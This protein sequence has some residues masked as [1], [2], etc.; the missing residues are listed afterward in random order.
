MKILEQH[1]TGTCTKTLKIEVP[2]DAV[3]TELDNVYKEF[4]ANAAVPGFRKGKAP[5]KIVQMRYGKHLNDE[6]INKAVEN[7]F[8]EA[9]EEIKVKPVTRA[10]IKKIEKDNEDQPVVVEF[11]FEHKPMFEL[12]DISSLQIEQPSTE[13]SETDIDQ[14]LNQM[15]E[16]NAVFTSI[17]DRPVMEND[18]VVIQ[19]KATF[20]DEP[21]PEGTNDEIQ[22]AVGSKRYIQGLEDALIGM[23][24]G[25]SKTVAL[26]LPDDFPDEEKRGKEVQFEILVK[27]IT[28]KTL[29]ELDDEFAKDI[30]PFESLEQL[31]ESLR[32]RYA[33]SAEQ[34]RH[35]KL[36][37]SIRQELLRLNQFDVP[38]SQVKAQYEYINTYQDS[39]YR[40]YGS[41]LESEVAQNKS[42]LDNNA[43]AAEEEVRLSYILEKI[44]E[45]DDIEITEEEF[46]EFLQR[47]S[48]GMDI[49]VFK[50]RIESQGIEGYYR[51]LALEEKVMD[52]LVDR[53]KSKSTTH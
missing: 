40:R 26:N 38:P 13:V 31:K 39:E 52:Y 30:G 21:F 22:I 8:K 45:V 11:K 3:N 23:K 44:A 25:E 33:Q 9:I 16:R 29:P 32:E 20:N 2:R 42:L 36:I 43:K 7:S 24:I 41:S 28:V 10:E 27:Q 37:Q 51:K 4:I 47:V 53:F 46:D 35:E 49:D 19:T 18:V 15:R 48:R 17:D 6:A 34:R 1:D 14:V 12:A 50:K 5:R